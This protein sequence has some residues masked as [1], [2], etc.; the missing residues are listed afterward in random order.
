VALRDALVAQ[1]ANVAAAVSALNPSFSFSGVS[2]AATTT[3]NTGVADMIAGSTTNAAVTF[4]A[5]SAFIMPP[6][7]EKRDGVECPADYRSGRGLSVIHSRNRRA[8]SRR[9]P[10]F[11]ATFLPRSRVEE[12]QEE[13]R[14][15][16]K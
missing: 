16:R 12:R 10:W 2:A 8:S 14:P 6:A 3:A 11:R 7:V 13:K 4:T 1:Q 5:G 9:Q 15:S